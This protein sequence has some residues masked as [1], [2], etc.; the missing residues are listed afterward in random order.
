MPF[1]LWQKAL[2]GAA[3][4]WILL[5]PAALVWGRSESL[6]APGLPAGPAKAEPPAPE[7]EPEAGRITASSS[8]FSPE[9]VVDEKG[10]K[11]LVIRD[12]GDGGIR[13]ENLPPTVVHKTMVLEGS[14]PPAAGR[15]PPEE[16]PYWV[17]EARVAERPY[18]QA[19]ERGQGLPYW[20]EREERDDTPYWQALEAAPEAPPDRPY[21]ELAPE[22][23][24]LIASQVE[25]SV[26]AP[27]PVPEPAGDLRT[28]SYFMYQDEAGI[29]HLTNVP[30]DPRYR[31][32]TVTVSLQRGLAG[33]RTG[34]MRFTH[35][36]LRPIIMRAAARYRLDPAL[37]AAVIRSESAFDAHAVSWAGAQ[38][39]MQ[40][41][42]GTAREVGCDDPFD[43]EQNIMGGSR[44]LRRM[45]D[46]FGG[47]LTL[48]L[49]AYNSGPERVRRL[50][51]VPNISETKNYVVIVSRN[52]ERYKGQF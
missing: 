38:G 41:M 47:D 2:V 22:R 40:L 25:P 34:R 51:R 14:Q 45:L 37:I 11:T 48:A 6:F 49:A 21:W 29:R 52:Y 24:E 4:L 13:S 35:E 17:V 19:E 12:G 26:T 23:V 27:P 44:Y 7:A 16:K 43:P 9:I 50:W 30:V 3:A 5:A 10:H 31:E 15:R 20:L 1:K 32:F 8:L 18:F 39:L 28:I 33:V 42:P 46:I 36:S